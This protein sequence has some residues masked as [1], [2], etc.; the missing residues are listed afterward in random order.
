MDIQQLKTKIDK[1]RLRISELNG[2]PFD[3]WFDKEYILS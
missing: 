3:E 1:T 2:I